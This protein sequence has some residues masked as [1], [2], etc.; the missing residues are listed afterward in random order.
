[1]KCARLKSDMLENCWRL[2]ESHSGNMQ[3][4]SFPI[5][6]LIIAICRR[7]ESDRNVI[8]QSLLASIKD[9]ATTAYALLETRKTELTILSLLQSY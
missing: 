8:V 3:V 6:D 9:K 7:S 2:L 1:M 4:L 5:A